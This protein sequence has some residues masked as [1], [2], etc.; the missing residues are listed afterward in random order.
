MSMLFCEWLDGV[1]FVEFK[2]CL[3]NFHCFTVR[4]VSVIL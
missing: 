3:H 4:L 2:S 1:Y